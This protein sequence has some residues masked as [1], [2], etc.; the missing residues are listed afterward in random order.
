MEELPRTYPTDE[1][2]LELLYGPHAVRVSDANGERDELIPLSGLSQ[3]EAVEKF[4]DHYV[5]MGPGVHEAGGKMTGRIQ[6]AQAMA[7][8]LPA[9]VIAVGTFQ[10]SQRKMLPTSVARYGNL[11]ISGRRATPEE[12]ND[13]AAMRRREKDLKDQAR[14]LELIEADKEKL[15]LASYDHAKISVDGKK[16]FMDLDQPATFAAVRLLQ[17]FMKIEPSYGITWVDFKRAIWHNMSLAEREQ[18]VTNKQAFEANCPKKIQDMIWPIRSE[19]LIPLGVVE[20]RGGALRNNAA[21]ALELYESPVSEEYAEEATRIASPGAPRSVFGVP[22]TTERNLDPEAVQICTEIV[23]DLCCRDAIG[24]QDA[25]EALDVVMSLEGKQAIHQLIEAKRLDT[26]DPEDVIAR[27][28]RLAKRSLGNNA[29]WSAR[30]MRTIGGNH[31]WTN[32]AGGVRQTGGAIHGSNATKT[33]D[34]LK[35]WSIGAPRSLKR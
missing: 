3:M 13:I 8:L 11:A 1:I 34:T 28:H 30:R 18:L 27:I 19:L 10:D 15:Q 7:Q 31:M 22:E 6:N 26:T 29:Y 24:Q 9:E 17:E 4:S 33:E 14:R 16:Y 5:E 35:R 32:R 23:T 21:I 25:V 20:L 12:T 2:H